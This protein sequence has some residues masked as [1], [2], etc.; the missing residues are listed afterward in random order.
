MKKRFFFIWE[1]KQFPFPGKRKTLNMSNIMTAHWQ[2]ETSFLFC[3][4]WTTTIKSNALNRKDFVYYVMCTV[5]NTQPKVPPI[6]TIRV[7]FGW[8]WLF[9]YNCKITLQ[10]IFV[11]IGIEVAFVFFFLV[12]RSTYCLL[13]WICLY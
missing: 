13:L 12:F 5:L 1:K 11:E 10:I 8:I 6:Q 7:C 9:L 3:K 4:N 2:S